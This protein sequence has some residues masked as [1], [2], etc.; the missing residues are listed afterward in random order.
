[1]QEAQPPHEVEAELRRQGIALIKGSQDLVAGLADAGVVHGNDQ[2]RIVAPAS[3]LFQH[4]LE[5]ILCFPA[6]AAVKL[7]IGAPVPIL[8]T[9]GPESTRESPS[10]QSQQRS[11]GLFDRA[12]AG[13]CSGEG[14][15]PGMKN[16]EQGV[17]QYRFHVSSPHVKQ[18]QRKKKSLMALAVIRPD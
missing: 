2:N 6:G 16:P 15:C 14:G 5:Q 9:E 4:G 1:M 17:K 10:A 3:A 11:H 12:V 18:I 8:T 7:V 13:A